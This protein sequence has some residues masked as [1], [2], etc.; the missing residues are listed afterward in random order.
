M[1]V[2]GA[3]RLPVRPAQHDGQGLFILPPHTRFQPAA[4][5][6]RLSQLARRSPGFGISLEPESSPFQQHPY[7]FQRVEVVVSMNDAYTIVVRLA[8]LLDTVL[9]GAG[10]SLLYIT[11]HLCC[12]SDLAIYRGLELCD[13]LSSRLA[14]ASRLPAEALKPRLGAARS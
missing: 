6:L 9:R 7:P 4:S 2:G 1:R 14:S 10:T 5:F 8:V 11:L 13:R 12:T 3:A